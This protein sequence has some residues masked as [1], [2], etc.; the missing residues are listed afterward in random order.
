VDLIAFQAAHEIVSDRLRNVPIPATSSKRAE[1]RATS[2]DIVVRAQTSGAIRSDVDPA[3]TSAMLGEAAY[4]IARSAQRS[5][6]LVD[7]FVTIAMDGLR[8]D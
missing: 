6:E 4:A 7:N 1:L 3:V 8:P 2:T 5:P